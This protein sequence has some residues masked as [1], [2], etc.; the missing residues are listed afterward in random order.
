MVAWNTS[1][2]QK[3]IAQFVAF[4]GFAWLLS[5]VSTKRGQDQ[6]KLCTPL[7]PYWNHPRFLVDNLVDKAVAIPRDLGY[8]RFREHHHHT[9][10]HEEAR[11]LRQAASSLLIFPRVRLFLPVTVLVFMH[12]NRRERYRYGYRSERGAHVTT[13]LAA[14]AVE[15]LISAY[16]RLVFHLI[17]GM[18]HD[19]HQSE[20]LTQEVFLTA[21]RGI[22]A[23]QTARGAQFQAKAWLLHITVNTVRMYL[24]RQRLMHFV[25]FSHLETAE[26]AA[27]VISELAAP[28]QPGGYSTVQGGGDPASL[29]AERDAVRRA[30]AGLPDPLRLP[31]LLSVVGGLSS[32]EI[33]RILGLGEAAIRQRLSRARRQFRRLYTLESGDV[34]VDAATT[35]GVS[36]VPGQKRRAPAPIQWVSQSMTA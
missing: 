4:R 2:K 27:F 9:Y 31:L 13:Q 17:H 12:L 18:I 7:P 28:V 35:T 5:T 23:A 10:R 16:G 26:A 29:V 33:A 21:F 24:R 11:K 3:N 32:A 36:T 30:L 8:T 14:E 1:R 15:Q 6:A 19:W 22:D 20:D 25:P 34:L